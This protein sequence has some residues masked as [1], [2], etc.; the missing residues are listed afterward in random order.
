MDIM[1]GSH[2]CRSYSVCRPST[3]SD[4]IIRRIEHEISGASCRRSLRVE[5][6]GI[7]IKMMNDF[8]SLP[9]FH[10]KLEK[11]KEVAE[12]LTVL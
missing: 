4:L 3:I 7:E 5:G 2:L 1:I 9:D 8:E 11:A 10:D 6:G 12:C